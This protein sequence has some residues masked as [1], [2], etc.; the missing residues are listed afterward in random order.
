MVINKNASLQEI[1]NTDNVE[2]V[3]VSVAYL[4]FSDFVKDMV[5]TACGRVPF[6]VRYTQLLMLPSFCDEELSEQE[7][8]A[9]KTEVQDFLTTGGYE[10][11]VN[12][13]YLKALRTMGQGDT[14]K[15]SVKLFKK[16]FSMNV[17]K[18]IA[19][20]MHNIAAADGLSKGEEDVIKVI[21]FYW[22]D[23]ISDEELDKA[24]DR[25]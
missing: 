13:I 12:D 14:F 19:I 5:D 2:Q 22:Y 7:K 17:L 3:S 1:F 25:E 21:L 24:L 10:I 20:L 6:A 23:T 16:Y 4:C 15:N 18:N 11:T 8:E 9:I